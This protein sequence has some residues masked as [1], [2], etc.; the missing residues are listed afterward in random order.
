MMRRPEPYRCRVC[1][2]AVLSMMP[3]LACHDS[4][5]PTL[6]VR[7]TSS[8]S[9]PQETDTLVARVVENGTSTERTY[10]LGDPPRDAWPQILPVIAGNNS[11]KMVTVA[12]EL[13][14]SPVGRPSVVVGYGETRAEFPVAGERMVDLD[15]PRACVDL[16][17]DGYGNG[18]GC[19]QPDCDDRR[20]DV[21]SPNFSLCPGLGSPDGGA[22]MD[23][24]AT[25]S[26]RPSR[27]AGVD[28]GFPDLCGARDVTCAANETCLSGQC[29]RR[30][31]TNLDCGEFD[32]GCINPPGICICRRMCN[33]NTDCGP[34]Q[35]RDGCCRI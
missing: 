29:Y 23:A 34:Y 17:G 15:V 35:C 25:D 7:I 3:I 32:L 4:N 19:A 18:F 26:G 9:I 10:L 6:L 20:A 12:G 28:G 5:D 33:N 1:S 8:L 13:R 14:F 21:P 2:I 31:E 27:D 30:C 22:S 11:A 16:D 24:G